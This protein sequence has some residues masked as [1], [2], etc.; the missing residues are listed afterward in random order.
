M[1]K[2]DRQKIIA[3]LDSLNKNIKRLKQIKNEV[4]SF[5]DYSSNIQ[6]LGSTERYLQLGL[7]SM[8]D[9]I[10]LTI[11]DMDVEKPEDNYEAVSI[12]FKKK[13]IS[14]EMAEKITKMIGLRNI[15]VHEYEE[16]DNQKIYEVLVQKISDLE[17]FENTIRTYIN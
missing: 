1:T 13:I 10:H 3:K 6:I 8:I 7:Q 16:I 4:K 12:L 9:A 11:I 17:E 14:D 5:E 15:L 2:T